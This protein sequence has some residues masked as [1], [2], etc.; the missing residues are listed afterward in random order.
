YKAAMQTASYNIM[1][2]DFSL[3]QFGWFDTND[4]RYAFLPNPSIRFEISGEIV[5]EAWSLVDAGA[6][7]VEEALMDIS[8]VESENGAPLLRYENSEKQRKELRHPCSHF[9]IGFHSENRWPL[10]R[11]L[12]PFAF[13]LLVS[14]FYYS[15]HWL[16]DCSETAFGQFEATLIEERRDG[17]RLLPPEMFSQLERV[18]FHIA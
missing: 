2:R 15:E 16:K 12:T 8:S 1:L 6:A 3:L 11:V 17:C 7:S 10:A 4:V 13:T 5:K 9:H 18:S 14:K